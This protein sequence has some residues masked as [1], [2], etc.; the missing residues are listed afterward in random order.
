MA[1][2]SNFWSSKLCLRSWLRTWNGAMQTLLR[3]WIKV[4][5]TLLR[6]LNRDKVSWNK[7]FKILSFWPIFNNKNHVKPHI[8][9]EFIQPIWSLWR[10]KKMRENTFKRESQVWSFDKSSDK[11]TTVYKRSKYNMSLLLLVCNHLWTTH[12]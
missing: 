8:F 10:I 2:L 3:T 12:I 6:T 9:L 7:I 1:S 5:Q 11:I 4:M